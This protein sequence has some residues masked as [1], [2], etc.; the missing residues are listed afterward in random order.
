MKES[1]SRA[2]TA[3]ET[4]PWMYDDVVRDP[5][6]EDAGRIFRE[7][8][9]RLGLDLPVECRPQVGHDPL[10]DEVHQ[11]RLGVVARPLDEVDPDDGK[12]DPHEHLGI[13]FQKDLVEGRFDEKGERRGRRTDDEHADHGD[14]KFERMRL[15]QFQ[16]PFENIHRFT[17]S[18][19]E[20]M[21]QAIRAVR[22]DAPG[23]P[24]FPRISASAA[25][26]SRA[27]PCRTMSSLTS[28]A[29]RSGLASSWIS[30]GTTVRPAM[31]FTRLMWSTRMNLRPMA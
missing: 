12:R 23:V 8:G 15:R 1:L 6:H 31:I 24:N 20:S 4:A 7:E 9:E 21:S 10:A 22:C 14:G 11:D 2:V 29:I 5:G 16:Q 17:L 3:S 30:S 25:F 13:F 19:F 27:F 26:I 28:A 18:S